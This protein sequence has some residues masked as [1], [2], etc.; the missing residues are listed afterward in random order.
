MNDMLSCS[1]AESLLRRHKRTQIRNVVS[2]KMRELG[3]FLISLG[4]V[5]GIRLLF[6]ALNP[7]FFDNIIGSVRVISGYCEE[8]KT[9]KSGSLALHMGTTLK[10]VC[11]IATK[12]IIKKS[13][14]VPCT[15]AEEKLK[16]IKRL[17]HL[18][19]N[20]WSSE[21]SSLALKNFKENN[22]SSPK[23]LPLTQDVVKFQKFVMK[24]ANEASNA[25][26]ENQHVKPLTLL[27]NRKRIGEIQYLTTETYNKEVKENQQSEFLDCL[28]IAEKTLC[29]DF[30]RVVTGGKGS[31]PVAIL[32][33]P[34][35]QEFIA[36]LISFRS[37]CV[38]ETN[39]YLFGNPN[40]NG[41]LSGYHIV[42]KLAEET[43]VSDTSLFTSTRLRKQPQYCRQ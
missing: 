37:Y 4:N 40:T 2:N 24:E 1:Y 31:R 17:K 13:P 12:N 25:L 21:I 34:D 29:K 10:Q 15:N 30:K 42:K 41:W 11:D 35:I 20:H 18:I 43:G 16:D 32:F 28:S 38:S 3:R 36:L 14:I 26:K 6:D 33:P 8:T 23:L 7:Q 9:F 19:E 27:I 22:Y 39:P 5:T